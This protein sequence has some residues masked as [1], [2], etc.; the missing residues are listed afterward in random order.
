[1]VGKPT[2]CME[3]DP[4]GKRAVAPVI[5]HSPRK[6]TSKLWI[7]ALLAMGKDQLRSA[8]AMSTASS[9]DEGFPYHHT[10]SSRARRSGGLLVVAHQPAFAPVTSRT[11]KT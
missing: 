8:V 5:K 2:G 11:S 10:P 4:G 1:M 9:Y 3:H 7:A 6:A